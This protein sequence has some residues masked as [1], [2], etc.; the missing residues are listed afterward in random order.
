MLYNIAVA[1]RTGIDYC[2]FPILPP[3]T[4]LHIL[5]NPLEGVPLEWIV[6]EKVIVLVQFLTDQRSVAI[7]Q[8]V[9]R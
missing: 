8:A 7:D 4:I 5:D 1:I 2:D 3:E 6:K 9:F